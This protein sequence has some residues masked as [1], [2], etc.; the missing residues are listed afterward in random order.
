MKKEEFLKEL[1]KKLN[2][3][4]KA[5]IEDHVSFYKEMI[6]DRV[7]DGKTEDEAIREIGDVDDVVKQI[8]AETPLSRIVK[9][10][11][12]PKRSLRAW[13]VIFLILGFPLW[14]PLFLVVLLLFFLAIG[15]IW[16]LA[17]I[18]YVV[19]ASLVFTTIDQKFHYPVMCKNTSIVRQVVKQYLYKEFPEYSKTNNYF[20]CNGNN[21]DLYKSF[22]ENGIKDGDTLVLNK[23]DDD[24]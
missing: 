20:L 1:R 2:G 22:Q 17:L 12:R 8:L 10:R 18:M 19:F 24:D 14:F 5:D 21:I 16:L 6:D 9:E 3:L 13:E 11:M 7:D 4:P 23:I 15:M